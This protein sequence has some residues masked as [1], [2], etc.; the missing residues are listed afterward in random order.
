MRAMIL[1]A[2]AEIDE[3]PPPLTLREVE[4][5]RPG[6]RELR[7]RVTACAVCR[8]DLHV[9]EGDLPERIRVRPYVTTYSLEDANRDL[10]RIE[11]HV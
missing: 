9:I 2:S 6:E 11:R 5:P 4:P 7:V 10:H 8:T 3:S 1:D